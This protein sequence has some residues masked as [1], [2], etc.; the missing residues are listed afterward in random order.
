MRAMFCSHFNA[1]FDGT[2][3]GRHYENIVY[4]IVYNMART[5]LRVS[6]GSSSPVRATTYQYS[7]PKSPMTT[8]PLARPTPG[9]RLAV[10]WLRRSASLLLLGLL[11]C[12]NPLRAQSTDAV[13]T[14]DKFVA[15]AK[16]DD[17][18]DVLPARESG[19]VFGTSRPLVATP[20]WVTG[21]ESALTEPF[22]VHTV[23]DFVS[24]TAGTFTG[25]YFGVPG[26]L[27]VRGERADNFFR[28]F[29][30][31]ENRGN[32]PT[33]I[34][35]ADYVEIIKGPPPPIYGG[36]K[37]GGILNFVP[38][39]AESK[40]AKL[41]DKPTG[42]I[43][44]TA[45]TYNKKVASID[46]GTPFTVLGKKSGAY[47]FVQ[48]EDSG[49]YYKNIY[50]RSNLAQ[51]AVDTE[52]TNSVLL[53]YGVMAQHSNLNQSLGW[54]RVTQA[55]I[56]GDGTYLAGRPKLNLDTNHDGF[57]SPSELNAYSLSQYAFA[58]PFPYGALTANQQAAMA[59]DPATIQTVKLSHHT[60]QAERIDFSLTDTLTGFFD[61][62]K[63]FSP[64]FNLKNQSFYDSM[65]QT[66]YFSYGFTA[67]YQ[68]VV[69]ETKPTPI[70]HG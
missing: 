36:G 30:R 32:F 55:M 14:L 5:L 27:D 17:I 49:S 68:Q 37:V 15:D 64:D 39:T 9:L 44:V 54:N 60:V 21:V 20:R 13:V 31:V 16:A 12:S 53:E 19:S 22:G 29:R 41:I 42:V 52:L 25:N 56:D 26:S 8:L 18:Y 43:T 63:T 62:T 48:S 35:S 11:A 61:I 40:T 24:V 1:C 7:Q 70:H 66:K 47:F 33:A 65:N 46:Y 4:I 57:L 51:V 10:V 23:N 58:N 67:D 6:S 50:N 59:L 3:W 2:Q 34:A 38:K 69:F 28:G 45:G